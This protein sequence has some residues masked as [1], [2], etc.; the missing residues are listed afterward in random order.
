MRLGPTRW[1]SR[2]SRSRRSR[3]LGEIDN[4]GG[5]DGARVAGF[6]PQPALRPERENEA[7]GT[8]REAQLFNPV[9]GVRLLGRRAREIA[10]HEVHQGKVDRAVAIGSL[11]MNHTASVSGWSAAAWLAVARSRWDLA[12]ANSPRS[13]VITP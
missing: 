13:H 1:P 8:L 2:N 5:R 12:I 7:I 11:G 3:A 9:C 10:A 6:H 4:G